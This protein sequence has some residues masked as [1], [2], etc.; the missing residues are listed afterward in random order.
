MSAAT[1]TKKNGEKA[2]TKLESRK[3]NNRELKNFFI[4]FA[5]T[6]GKWDE[7]S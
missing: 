2:Q 1:Q 3:G 7:S 4:S 5:D 6:F